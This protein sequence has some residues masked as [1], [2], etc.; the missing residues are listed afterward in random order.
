VL[1][2]RWEVV[3]LHHSGKPYPPGKVGAKGQEWKGQFVANEG[4][5]MR[6]ILA[7]LQAQGL[8]PLLMQK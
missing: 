8:G 1:N 7:H 3:A 6:A 2:A 4:I 5:P